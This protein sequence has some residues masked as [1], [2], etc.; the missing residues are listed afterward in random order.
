MTNTVEPTNQL[1]PFLSVLIPIIKEFRK[2]DPNMRLQRVLTLLICAQEK[3]IGITEVAKRL[4]GTV[5]SASRNINWLSNL[6]PSG[7]MNLGDDFI[8]TSYDPSNRRQKII[9]ISPPGHEF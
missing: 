9:K 2:I 6:N 4:N 5:S 7:F 1:Q 8:E 3:G